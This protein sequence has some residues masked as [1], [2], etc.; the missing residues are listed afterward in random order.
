MKKEF[1]YVNQILGM[2]PGTLVINEESGTTLHTDLL[3]TMEAALE[4]KEQ[5]LADLQAKADAAQAE[6]ET[7]KAQLA[8]AE[9]Q[10]TAAEEKV[11]QAEAAVEN[12]STE[13]DE[14]KAQLQGATDANE[15]LKAKHAEELNTL[16]AD[17]AEKTQQVS[18]NQTLIEQL[19]QEKEAAAEESPAN[20][21]SDAERPQL[22]C[23]APQWNNALTPAE[24]RRILDEY[25]QNLLLMAR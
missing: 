12:L 13:R 1:K 25:N 6:V 10:K 24:N 18:D 11:A 14:L 3:D 2:A 21:G 7:L 23:N 17:L 19:K 4:A 5:T 8:D 20:N 22:A 16:K 9:V 15:E